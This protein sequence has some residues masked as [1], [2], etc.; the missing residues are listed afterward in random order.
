MKTRN[1]HLI[2]R[3]AFLAIAFLMVTLCW[4]QKK[5]LTYQQAFMQGEPRLTSS[6]PRIQGW[7]DDEYFLLS[8]TEGEGKERKTLAMKTHAVTGEEHV[9]MDYNAYKD[10]LP[11]GFSLQRNAG[12]FHG[13]YL[14]NQENDLYYFNKETGLFR[15]LTSNEASEKNPRFSP[16]GKNVAFTRNHN[17]YV[18]DVEKGLEQQLT[19]DGSDVIYNGWAS[20]VYYE[21]ILGRRSRYTAFWWAPNSNKIAFLRFDDSDVPE[22]PLYRADG[23]HGEL[24]IAHYPKP[25]DPNP[26]VRLGILDLETMK[27]IWVDTKENADHYVAWPFWT[28]DSKQL[29]FQWMNRGQDHIKIYSADPE[30]GE[31]IVIYDEKQAAWV[32]FFEDLYFLKDGSGFLLRSNVDGW[33]HLYLYNMQ[34]KLKKRLT[35]GKWTVRSISLVDESNEMVYFQGWQKE[36]T[37]SHLYKVGFNGKN[38]K[39]LTQKPGTHRCQVSPG[40]S[41]FIDSFSN[42][43]TPTMDALYGTDG[44]LI[45]SLGDSKTDLMDEYDLGKV[46]MFTIPSGDGYDLPAVWVL[47]PDFEES[48][49]YP[50]IFSIYGGPGAGTVR[51]SFQRLSSQFMA[52]NGIITISVDHRAS[53]HFGKQGIA[54]MHRNLGKWEMHDLTAAVKWLR[55]KDFID[56][57]KIGITGGSYGGYTTCMALTYGADYF[58][59]G[60]A[61][62]SVTD[63]KLYDTV[64]TERYMDTPKENP[65]GYKF[66]SAMTHADKY[67]GTM[68][69]TH[70][71]MDDNV[72]MQ[73]TI[74]FISKLEDLNKD[75][76]LMLYPNARHGVG[77]PKRNHSAREGVQFWF[78]H[79]LGQ[80]LVTE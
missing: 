42:I 21:E 38:L 68:L 61:Q 46:E 5:K 66:G 65:E 8:K 79:F 26:K 7:M 29:F 17:L 56:P 54:L 15:R 51:N 20:W 71:T 11:E 77:Y 31:K 53:G 41:Y 19:T 70:G 45:R 37:G 44:K 2:R 43:E 72:H 28:T 30:T 69:I 60:I 62:Y 12:E 25:G 1:R 6:L 40:G 33:D 52:Q 27:T 18:L 23:V 64:Y 16:D 9:V 50:V 34:G 39:Q 13:S 67:K 10:K 63:W 49:K 73:N 4:A 58:T 24:E 55:G 35:K 76:K 78:K 47:P 80:E 14:F 32:E 48:K 36:S 22:F 75:F 59:H 74:Q 3:I 57:D